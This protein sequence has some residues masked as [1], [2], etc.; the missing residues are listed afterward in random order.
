MRLFGGLGSVDNA[1]GEFIETDKRNLSALSEKWLN[2]CEEYLF[3]YGDEFD[4][5]WSGNLS[6]I[7]TKFIS[8]SGAALATFSSNDRPAVSIAL[9]TGLSSE[10]ESSV[11]KMFVNSLRKVELVR[12]SAQSSEPFEKILSI[13]S[14][15]LAIIVP[16]GDPEISEQDQQ[17]T[18]ELSLHFAAAYLMRD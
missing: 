17:L 1:D 3:H 13:E 6:H 8:E 15:P 10:V 2:I 7:K 12:A 16:W 5:P 18:Q 14:R 4:A 11:L 9:V